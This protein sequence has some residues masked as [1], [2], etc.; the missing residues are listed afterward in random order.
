LGSD[1]TKVGYLMCSHPEHSVEVL[2][3]GQ[4]AEEHVIDL[5]ELQDR[6]NRLVGDMTLASY[7]HTIPRNYY[8]TTTAEEVP[9][10]Q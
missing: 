5:A 9:N 2:P 8:F 10:G 6:I 7:G 1:A 4:I 3:D